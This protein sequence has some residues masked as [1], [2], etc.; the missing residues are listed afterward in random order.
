VAYLARHPDAFRT[1]SIGIASA[2]GRDSSASYRPLIFGLRGNSLS[3]AP[4]LPPAI[5]SVPAEPVLHANWTDSV[6]LQ[7]LFSLGSSVRIPLA[8]PLTVALKGVI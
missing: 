6:E 2:D 1:T 7:D 4:G 3:L 8:G 5:G